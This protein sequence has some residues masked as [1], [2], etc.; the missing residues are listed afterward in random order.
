[1]SRSYSLS[2]DKRTSINRMVEDLR[3]LS[4]DT[5]SADIVFR[6]GPN[7][8]VVHA[9]RIILMARLMNISVFKKSFFKI[10]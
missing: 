2:V 4:E 7:E 8:E 1:M 6:L 10:E 9:H 3:K 5:E